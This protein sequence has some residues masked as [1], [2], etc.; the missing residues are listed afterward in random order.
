MTNVNKPN[1]TSTEKFNARMKAWMEPQGIKFASPDV[2]TAYRQ[3]VQM[4]K[5]AIQLK[6]PVRVPICPNI[7]F[8]PFTYAGVTHQEAMY[9][10][11]KLGKALRKFHADFMP[12][13]LSGSPIY[14]S[15]KVLELLDYKLYSWPGHGIS[16]HT[17]YQCLESEY[18]K[19]D[20]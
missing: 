4:V 1:L 20:E 16:P 18:M 8:Y 13:S 5:D 19:A 6:K 11:D 3:R 14:G 15:G 10:Y 2:E 9:D 17:P 7:G 12:D